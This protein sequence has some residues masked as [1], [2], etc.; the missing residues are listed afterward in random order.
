MILPQVGSATEL[1][2]E[3]RNERIFF[4]LARVVCRKHKEVEETIVVFEEDARNRES[5]G[6]PRVTSG[7]RD[8]GDPRYHLSSACLPAKQPANAI[9]FA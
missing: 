5:K 2:Q 4:S 9:Q 7:R 6:V 3:Q 1:S 8:D